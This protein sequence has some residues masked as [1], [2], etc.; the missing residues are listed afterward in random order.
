MIE[1]LCDDILE[2]E[3]RIFREI[4]DL[5]VVIA[6]KE[7]DDALLIG[8]DRMGLESDQL[9]VT[10]SSKLFKHSKENIV[11]GCAG[12]TEIAKH[13]FSPWLQSLDIGNDWQTLK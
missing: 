5:T 8:A 12:N 10:S 11:W 3:D 7:S 2:K 4:I 6:I 9:K 13:E 1:Q